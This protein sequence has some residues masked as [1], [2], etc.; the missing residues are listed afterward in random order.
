[1]NKEKRIRPY[2]ILLVFGWFLS[3]PGCM[4]MRTNDKKAVKDFKKEGLGISINRFESEEYRIRYLELNMVDSLSPV[5]IFVHGAPG[6]SDAFFDYL[7]DSSLY[8]KAVL[9]AVDRPGYG[10][11]NFGDAEVSIEKQA[12]LLK[13]LL[14]KYEGRK[15]ILVGHSYGGAI[16]AKMAM[17]YRVDGLLFLAPAIDPSNEKE[18]WITGLGKFPLTRFFTPVSL[19]VATDE[20]LAHQAALE[21]EVNHWDEIDCRVVYIHGKKDKIV[22]FANTA[23]ATKK[24]SHCELET[25]VLDDAGHFFIWK[26]KKVVINYLLD[27]IEN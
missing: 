9:V 23:F 13:P 21:Q 2:L 10:F 4:K 27:L 8:S 16:I 22:P 6:S 20:K 18:F 3:L 19:R 5:V 1:M 12:K 25:V 17:E 26:Q 24:L 15:V 11:S 7:K 14:T